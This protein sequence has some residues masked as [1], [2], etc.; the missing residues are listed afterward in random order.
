V[1][2]SPGRRDSPLD[3]RVHPAAESVL[4]FWI[5]QFDQKESKSWIL[6]SADGPIQF[7]VPLSWGVKQIR[8]WT[9]DALTPTNQLLLSSAPLL[10]T[11]TAQ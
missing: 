3:A 1:L 5:C 11:N 7:P 6:W 10:L 4:V 2:T 8:N 9:G